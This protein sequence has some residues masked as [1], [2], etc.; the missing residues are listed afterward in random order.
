VPL[1]LPS[2][3]GGMR[4]P[5]LANQNIPVNQQFYNYPCHQRAAEFV[6]YNNPLVA[7]SGSVHQRLLAFRSHHQKC[8][9][10][11]KH[12]LASEMKQESQRADWLK[13]KFVDCARLSQSTTMASSSLRIASTSVAFSSAS[14]SNYDS[15]S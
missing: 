12:A 14:G 10:R 6:L 8:A 5:V 1:A 11:R 3:G 15:V 4:M 13:R 7:S 2:Y 9:S